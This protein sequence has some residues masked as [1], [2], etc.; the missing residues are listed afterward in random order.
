MKFEDYDENEKPAVT[1][2]SLQGTLLSMHDDVKSLRQQ[3][4]S[5]QSEISLVRHELKQLR[6]MKDLSERLSR[7]ER[8]LD[9]DDKS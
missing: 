5:M 4:L 7:A 8:R 3:S 6:D 9:E 1:M 2:E